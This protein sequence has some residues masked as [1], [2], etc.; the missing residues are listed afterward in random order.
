M[1][2]FIDKRLRPLR[3][4]QLQP[5][6]DPTLAL[7]MRGEPGTQRDVNRALD[8]LQRAADVAAILLALDSLSLAHLWTALSLDG[9]FQQALITALDRLPE[10][11]DAAAETVSA[12][13]DR[14]G[15]PARA[16]LVAARD[17]NID[18]IA[19]TTEEAIK[20]VVR[21]AMTAGDPLPAVAAQIKTVIGLT[22]RQAM[23]VA[24]Y[25]RALEANSLS[26]LQRALRDERWDDA[27]REAA[28]LGERLPM[29]DIDGLVGRYA[30]R[31][32]AS[33]AASIARTTTMQAANLGAKAGAEDAGAD[34]R[35]WLTSMRENVCPLCM[36]IPILNPVGVPMNQ[37]FASIEGPIDEPIEDTHTNCSC[38]LRYFRNGVSLPLA[39][40]A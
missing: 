23:A 38:S 12:T 25:R 33:R 1:I 36:S 34:R 35:F 29:R 14:L 13:F 32:R 20:A 3:A 39:Q 2:T 10:I 17:A 9:R 28:R 31:M 5:G 16:A 40:A 11:H 19:I 18:E 26:A 4:D 27:V 24:N 30:R 37:P 22:P 6:D 21:Q 7:A 8:D 15:T